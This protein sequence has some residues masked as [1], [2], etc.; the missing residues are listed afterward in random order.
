MPT[1]DMSLAGA[2]RHGV[3]RYTFLVGDFVADLGTIGTWPSSKGG[4][5]GALFALRYDEPWLAGMA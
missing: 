5:C 4:E 3:R 1:D 2:P